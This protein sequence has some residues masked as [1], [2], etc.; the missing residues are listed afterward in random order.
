MSS[1]TFL[2]ARSPNS[3]VSVRVM[4]LPKA[5]EE[6]LFHDR[7]LVLVVASYL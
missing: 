2:E 4:L 7:I 3:E 5:L 6:N 1:L